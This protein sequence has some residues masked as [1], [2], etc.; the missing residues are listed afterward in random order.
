MA[1]DPTSARRPLAFRRG[2]QPSVTRRGA[3]ST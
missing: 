1:R 3:V 2:R